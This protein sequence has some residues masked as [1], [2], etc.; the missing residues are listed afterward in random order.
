MNTSPRLVL[1]P[2]WTRS[3]LG[4]VAGSALFAGLVALLYAISFH[5]AAGTSDKAT[6]LLVGQ[7]VGS[8]NLLLHGWILPPGNYWTSDVTIYAIWTRLFGLYQGMLY[9]EPAIVAALAIVAGVL[10]VKENRTLQSSLAGILTLVVLLVFA[11]PPMA[12]WLVGNGFHI[13][14]A[15]YALVAFLLLRESTFGWRWV[16]AV[17]VLAFG[18]LGDLEIVA[19]A[20]LPLF[21]AGISAMLRRRSWRSGFSQVGAAIASAVIGEF[22]LRSTLAFGAFR[23][24]PSLPVAHLHQMATNLGHVF[25]YS[26]ELL[27]VTNGRFGTA[28]IP[29]GLL[30]VHVVGGLLTIFGLIAA[31]GS[32]VVGVIR[33]T[34]GGDS[35]ESDQ[36]TWRIDD[37]L[38]FGAFGSAALFVVLAGANGLGIHFLSIPVLFA[39]IL[40]GRV[41]SRAWPRLP[42]GRIRQSVAMFGVALS[43]VLAT[44]IAIEISLPA[45]VQP[46]SALVAFLEQHDLR[47]GIGGYWT[48]AIT[49]VESRGQITVRPVEVAPN[50]KL[51]RMMTQSSERWYRDQHFQFVVGDTSHAG[52]V[53]NAAARKTWGVPTHIFDVGQY[54][55]YVWGK[56]L[57]VLAFPPGA[58]LG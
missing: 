24:G 16:P 21:L 3:A 6:T 58:K 9:L 31:L 13:V 43:L 27:G 22:F 5:I 15:L 55:V 7:D 10:M 19:F 2:S 56:D 57:R 33:G 40:A 4:M 49:T 39:S 26:A 42:K 51:R 1:K 30:G 46:A 14:T 29:I 12:L 54:R 28:G 44:G 45:P 53:T 35:R 38:L 37:L 47:N 17:A 18:M 34:S 41:V 8:G 20:I 23:R 50:G 25:T 52:N 32:V 36:E 11:T 48:A